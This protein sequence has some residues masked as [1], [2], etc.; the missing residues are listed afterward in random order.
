MIPALEDT[1]LNGSVGCLQLIGRGPLIIRGWLG[2]SCQGDFDSD[3]L[4][5]ICSRFEVRSFK[6]KNKVFEFNYQS[7]SPHDV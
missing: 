5:Y 2:N 1:N 6:G 4:N 3:G 7:S